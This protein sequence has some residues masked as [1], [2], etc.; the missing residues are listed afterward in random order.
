VVKIPDIHYLS[1][2][3]SR[4]SRAFRSAFGHKRGEV[5]S[6]ADQSR[7]GPVWQAVRIV[8]QIA[9]FAAVPLSLGYGPAFSVASI[10]APLYLIAAIG[11]LAILRGARMPPLLMTVA[12]VCFGWYA[13]LLAIDMMHGGPLWFPLTYQ[14]NLLASNFVL[15]AFPFLVVGL[16]E[17]R[18]EMRPM[19]WAIKATLLVIACVTVYQFVV[20]GVPRPQGFSTN[21]IPFAMMCTIWGSCLLARA[22]GRPAI[23]W[24]RLGFALVALVPIALAGSKIVWLSALFAYG[25][26][27][28]AWVWRGARWRVLLAVVLGLIPIVWLLSQAAFVRD[29]FVQFNVDLAMFLAGDLSGATFGIRFAAALGGLRAFLDRP[30]FGYGMVQAKLAAT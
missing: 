28:V 18:V 7:P 6:I 2:L 27:F 26:L 23:G 9:A 5:T 12:Y 15:L 17:C 19:E 10:L 16:R 22:F 25:G 13:V 8:G 20:E 11:F 14:A 24:L 21:S 1:I 4:Q 30:L 3:A 29:R